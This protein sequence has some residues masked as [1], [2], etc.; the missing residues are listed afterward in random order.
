MRVVKRA[1]IELDAL[2]AARYNALVEG[3]EMPGCREQVHTGPRYYRIAAHAT[4][5]LVDTG[6]RDEIEREMG[7][8]PN[9]ERALEVEHAATRTRLL[10]GERDTFWHPELDAKL[11]EIY[12]HRLT[13]YDDAVEARRRVLLARWNAALFDIRRRVDVWRAGRRAASYE[14]VDHR[15]EWGST[16]SHTESP[17]SREDWLWLGVPDTRLLQGEIPLPSW[18][19][20]AETI[21]EDDVERERWCLEAI[22]RLEERGE[23]R[24]RK[25]RARE[26]SE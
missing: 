19:G 24:E 22:K 12:E 6:R 20:V 23:A 1:L 3:P 10:G 11:D 26:E 8:D 16:A 5:R 14:V 25:H 9:S 17:I 4:A 13:P 21:T 15:T 2:K 18:T 7:F